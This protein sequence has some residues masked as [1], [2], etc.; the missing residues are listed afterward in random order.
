MNNKASFQLTPVKKHPIMKFTKMKF[1]KMIFTH[2]VFQQK[3]NIS[4]IK[5]LRNT[6]IK[7]QSSCRCC[8]NAENKYP[9]HVQQISSYVS[10][11]PC[12]SGIC[13]NTQ[14]ISGCI[15]TTDASI[16]CTDDH[17][18][19]S[20]CKDQNNICGIG[21]D[22]SLCNRTIESCSGG[23]VGEWDG[24]ATTTTFGD[25]AQF[26]G[27]ISAS[28]ELKAA[29]PWS[30]LC[31]EFQTKNCLMNH[32][33]PNC[34]DCGNGHGDSSGTDCMLPKSSNPQ[35]TASCIGAESDPTSRFTC[36]KK[37]CTNPASYNNEIDKYGVCWK[38][39]PITHLVEE[40][41]NNYNNPDFPLYN[42]TNGK[43]IDGATSVN[44]KTYIVKLSQG[45][46]G[47]CSGGNTNS[48]LG[49]PAVP[50][51][52][53][54]YTADCVN[55]CSAIATPSID[56]NNYSDPCNIRLSTTGTTCNF[57][58]KM[59]DVSFTIDT[60]TTLNTLS[61]PDLSGGTCTL[62]FDVAGNYQ[63]APV[64]NMHNWCSG[65]HMHFDF[66]TNDASD[67]GLMQYIQ[68]NLFRYKRVQ[69]PPYNQTK[70]CIKKTIPS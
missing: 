45:C 17:A 64:N 29:V 48:C 34:A 28:T 43:S 27:K 8:V 25:N 53:G 44:D 37:D 58:E 35:Q 31:K 36:L 6:N 52:G 19:G 55:G 70:G 54:E 63:R 22:V 61:Q 14:G 7:T 67:A 18:D 26:C 68:T 32:M 2:N 51:S 10:P 38:I 50:K 21:G 59:Y 60:P 47:N 57:M 11:I 46:G 40:G 69:C 3:N 39:Q 24:W 62:P 1:T 23:I 33:C 13:H 65:A 42:Y 20:G 16:C 66:Y 5:L 9:S 12:I 15:L 41:V 4:N 56:L 30:I 49:G